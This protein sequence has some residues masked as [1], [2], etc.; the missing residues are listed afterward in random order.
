MIEF[1]I[2][3]RLQPQFPQENYREFIDTPIKCLRVAAWRL[4]DD[5]QLLQQRQAV[6]WLAFLVLAGHRHQQ[7]AIDENGP[8]SPTSAL[9][10]TGVRLTMVF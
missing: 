6:G 4:A 9:I 3:S 5:L 10:A 1:A 8:S 2:Y 7:R